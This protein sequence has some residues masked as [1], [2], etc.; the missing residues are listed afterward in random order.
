MEDSEIRK[1]VQ[2]ELRRFFEELAKINKKKGRK[3]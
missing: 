2:E 3:K 1:I